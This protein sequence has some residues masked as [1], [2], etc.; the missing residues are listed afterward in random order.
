MKPDCPFV[1]SALESHSHA[2]VREVNAGHEGLRV[3]GGWCGLRG[4]SGGWRAADT[5]GVEEALDAREAHAVDRS[6]GAGGGAFAVGGDQLV[7]VALIE[8]LD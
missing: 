4:S 5:G 7:D 8:A 6:E 2:A 1:A 3:R